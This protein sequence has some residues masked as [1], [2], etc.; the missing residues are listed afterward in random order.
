MSGSFTTYGTFVTGSILARNIASD[1]IA[2]EKVAVTNALS[3]MQFATEKAVITNALAT[4]ELTCENIILADIQQSDQFNTIITNAYSIK[5]KNGKFSVN[6]ASGGE[7]LDLSNNGNL[8]I[9][10][11]F[12]GNLKDSNFSNVKNIS[13]NTL[14][15]N[16]LNVH[17]LNVTGEFKGTIDLEDLATIK[18]LN[19][20]TLHVGNLHGNIGNIDIFASDSIAA[21]SVSVTDSL[22]ASQFAVNEAIVTDSLAAKEIAVEDFALAKISTVGSIG[23]SPTDDLPNVDVSDSYVLK[24]GTQNN[25]QII[26][27]NSNL[28]EIANNGTTI[29]GD[30]NITGGLNVSGTLG[31]DI[32]ETNLQNLKDLSLDNLT[33]EDI[34][35]NGNLKVNG[36][37]EASQAKI[38]DAAVDSLATRLLAVAD[39]LSAINIASQNASVT[40]ALSAVNVAV[41]NFAIS[42]NNNTYSLNVDESSLNI[43]KN[44]QDLISVSQNGLTVNGNI[45]AAEIKSNLIDVKDLNVSG[46]LNANL[47]VDDISNIKELD[48]ETLRVR[49]IYGQTGVID[50]VVSKDISVSDILDAKLN[51]SNLENIKDLSLD[52]L[53]VENLHGTNVTVSDTLDAK[54]NNSNLENIKDLSLDTINVNTITGTNANFNTGFFEDISAVN[55]MLSGDLTVQ[56]VNM[57]DLTAANVV[58]SGNLDASNIQAYTGNINT[59]VSND[60]ATIDASILGGLGAVDIATQ[61]MSVTEGLA[62][63]DLAVESMHIT[64]THDIYKLDVYDSELRIQNGNI[65]VMTLGI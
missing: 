61:N 1:E 7:I 60:F 6:N 8:K 37:L 12:D 63:K 34:T 13:L 47:D 49:N 31:A 22:S 65:E 41:Q 50:N 3:S 38:E 62:S 19:L 26:K 42:K 51:N 32:N 23:S 35:A 40:N 25:L 21:K 48:L 16:S 59:L 36:L 30:V 58:L 14:E 11:E 29:T 4:K 64:N 43:A 24:V 57:T 2:A 52:S 28:L 15:T 9:F 18:S 33:V 46:E 55:S 54:L 5:S 53:N 17:D 39:A 45:D 20:E 44:S 10:G 56:N 27:D